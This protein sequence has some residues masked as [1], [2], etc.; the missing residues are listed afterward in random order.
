MPE[1]VAPPANPPSEDAPRPADPPADRTAEPP[2]VAGEPSAGEPAGKPAA[3]PAAAAAEPA[4]AAQPE[5]AASAPAGLPGDA[6]PAAA[7]LPEQRAEEP[8]AKRSAGRKVLGVVGALLAIGVVAALKFGLGTAVAAAFDKDGTADAKAG[9]CLAELPDVAEGERKDASGAEV[10]ACTSTEAVY[11]VVGR[12]DGQTEA[13]ARTGKACEP[14]L[15][16]GQEG[17]FFYNIK[18]GSTGYLLCLTRKAA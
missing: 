11:T 2:A 9:D 6:A 15:Q 5:A 3:P 8:E 17:Y 10:V 16:P 14:F 12:V 18:P 7:G 1:Q 4:A 13:Q